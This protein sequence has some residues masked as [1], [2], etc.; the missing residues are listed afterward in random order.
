MAAALTAEMPSA[1]LLGRRIGLGRQPATMFCAIVG[2]RPWDLFLFLFEKYI[3]QYICA[4]SRRV[5][6][7]LML[8]C[9]HYPAVGH[10]EVL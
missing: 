3:I 5:V 10:I 7:N 2:R 8:I 9:L 6:D 1:L 4:R